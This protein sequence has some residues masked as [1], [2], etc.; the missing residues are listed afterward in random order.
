MSRLSLR[1]TFS[2]L[3]IAFFYA[4]CGSASKVSV[5]TNYVP[6]LSTRADPATRAAR[7]TLKGDF[8]WAADSVSLNEAVSRWE[9][10][11][12]AHEPRDG[13]YGDGFHKLHVDAAKFE[14][15]RVYY[16][17]G[18]TVDGDRLLKRIDPLTLNNTRRP[19]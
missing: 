8:E 16:L 10:F 3:L 11:L 5:G 9:N 1:L 2:A 7:G 18:R 17:L 15:M 19:K 6:V 14:L 12:K 13:E 4:A